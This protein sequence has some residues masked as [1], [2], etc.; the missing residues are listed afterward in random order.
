MGCDV[1]PSFQRKTIDVETGKESWEYILDHKYEGNRHYFLF[2]WLANVRNG[3]GFAGCDTGDAIRPLAAPRGLPE[4][5]VKLTSPEHEY[6]Y[7]DPAW[8]Q[9][10]HNGGGDF[11]DHSQ[12]WLTST[13]IIEGAKN[14]NAVHRRGVISMSEYLAWDKKTAL[15][16]W[17]GGIWGKGHSTVDQADVTPE[18]IR[19]QAYAS[20]LSRLIEAEQAKNR[21]VVKTVKAL[22]FED[23]KYN[24]I[25]WLFQSRPS[26]HEPKVE[27]LVRKRVLV[28]KTAKQKHLAKLNRYA[29][30]IGTISVRVQWTLDNEAIYKEFAYFI[31]EVKRL[32]ELYGEVRMVFGFDS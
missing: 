12:S 6:E 26:F 14:F 3:L 11:G 9:F 28:R 1:H 31:D 19:S 2:G 20:E 25:G 17:S 8:R 10:Y 5:L 23:D 29:R 13:E 24:N 18:Q 16:S 32:H 4:D 7:E 15:E 27:K 22:V 30:R 21:W